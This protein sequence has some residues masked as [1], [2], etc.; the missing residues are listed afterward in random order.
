MVRNALLSAALVLA[1]TAP[2]Q[3]ADHQ[4]VLGGFTFTPSR[5]TVQAGDTV[6]WLNTG[7]IHSVTAEDGSFSSGDAAPNDDPRWPFTHRF[8]RPGVF[9][10]VCI[11]HEF[12]NMRGVVE[13]EGPNH[14]DVP[15]LVQAEVTVSEGEGAA[16][17]AVRRA[18]GS[19][20]AIS[21]G[22][23]A[24]V[25]STNPGNATA[26]VDFIVVSGTL[27]WPDGDGA[28]RTFT[29]PILDDAAVEGEETLSLELS[30]PTGGAT[31]DPLS[32]RAVLRIVDEDAPQPLSAAE[33]SCDAA[34]LKGL[35]DRAAVTSSRGGTPGLNLFLTASG[36]FSGLAYVSSGAAEHQLVFSSNPEEMTLLRNPTRPQLSSLSLTRN[37]LS[38]D[39][40]KKGEAGELAVAVNPTLDPGAS[41]TLRIDNVDGPQGTPADAKPGRGLADLLTPCH[42]PLS[43]RDVHVFRVLSK[44]A[45]PSSPAA[46][47][48]ELALFR[49]ESPTSYRADVYPLRADGTPLGRLAVEIAVTFAATGE[50]SGGTMRVLGR[51][52]ASRAEHCTSVTSLTELALVPPAAGGQPTPAPAV[53]V[54]TMGTEGDGQPEAVVDW[55]TLLAGTSWRRPL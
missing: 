6:T 32:R 37:A 30:S 13:V 42:G 26:G 39:L 27:T 7:G 33:V 1:L 10:Y 49:G 50:L 23:S 44:V 17:V 8:D 3:G 31:L 43:T 12:L 4:V 41:G 22:Y 36:D 24:N 48:F 15:E 9:P 18:K 20:G 52:S 47:A 28:D 34:R 35:L 45:R 19:T 5:L 46:R 53:R 11:P 55:S 29:V 14:P 40:V 16:I 38:S 21:V 25:F 2:A 54:S 51:C